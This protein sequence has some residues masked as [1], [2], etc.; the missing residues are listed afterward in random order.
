MQ[1]STLTD[2]VQEFAPVLGPLLPPL[3]DCAQALADANDHE[4]NCSVLPTVRD[5][6]HHS[7]VLLEKVKEQQTFVLVFG[8][9][10]SGKSTLMNALAAT[11]VSEVTALPAYPCMVFVSHAAT[12][13][14]EVTRYDGTTEVLRDSTAL[15][16][17]VDEAHVELARELAAAED[18]GVTFDPAVHFP[19][20]LRR[21]D[22]H[23]PAEE[24][25]A[26]GAVLVDTPGL[27]TRMKFGY[28]AMTREFR[29]AA[30]CAVFVV[31]TDN[32][33]LEQVFA[34]FEDLLDMFTRIFLVVNVDPG[35][36]DLGPDGELMPSAEAKD[37]SSIVDAFHT[38]SMTARMRGA[39]EEGRLRIHT[40]DLLRSARRRLRNEPE[41]PA[42]PAGFSALRTD[43]HDFLSSSEYIVAFMRD[44]LRQS[45]MLLER[46]D[47]A[48][49]NRALFEI[50][51]R[52]E[53]DRV[54]LEEAR[55]RYAALD[56]AVAFDWDGA[57]DGFDARVKQEAKAGFAA[58]RDRSTKALEQS[59]DEWF[60]SEESLKDLVTAR[61]GGGLAGH[62]RATEEV[63][64]R[65]VARTAERPRKGLE[66][67]TALLTD[68][69]QVA[70]DVDIL[71][72]ELSAERL[73]GPASAAPRLDIDTIPVRRKFWDWILLRSARSI[74][75]RL[76]GSPDQP[77][78]AIPPDIKEARLGDAGYESL[79]TIVGQRADAAFPRH[80]AGTLEN[81]LK[82]HRNSF[83][84]A[85]D[86]ALE[87]R[88][89]GLTTQVNTLE[90]RVRFAD[91]VITPVLRLREVAGRTRL[92][93]GELTE[94]YFP[95]PTPEVLLPTPPPDGETD[96]EETTRA[97]EGEAEALADGSEDAVA[98]ETTEAH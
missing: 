27:Y 33:F 1:E 93:L 85:I 88:R 61:T 32:L 3:R 48:L 83:R 34:E 64:R 22:V 5:V 16:N 96:D 25:R 52:L 68:L 78:L 90:E 11:Y 74:R 7:G 10:K 41:D 15:K 59:L 49:A 37:A 56:R 14:F 80:E 65:A 20:A 24:L 70:V 63:V 28:D 50:A 30:A 97:A 21:I 42:D 62:A 47:G 84:H 19:E 4:I 66:L 18:R 98:S 38:F 77:S 6:A 31:K 26:S 9:L 39:D 91:G 29:H 71:S 53:E 46:L 76:F 57:L 51:R 36:Q 87:A 12:S 92:G 82:N 75:R 86:A 72:L 67:S 17:L 54:S 2:F 55:A 35:K 81:L 44:S 95:T 89:P 69:Q 13:S 43:L 94:R 23:L 40:V 79:R 60:A 58:T 73:P 45:E 8:P